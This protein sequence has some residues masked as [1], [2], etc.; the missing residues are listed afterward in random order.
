M[1]HPPSLALWKLFFDQGENGSKT[2]VNLNVHQ[3]AKEFPVV[4]LFSNAQ[5]KSN[6]LGWFEIYVYIVII[7]F[8]TN[9]FDKSINLLL[10]WSTTDKLPAGGARWHVLLVQKLQS[11]LFFA[12]ASPPAHSQ[13]QC[14]CSLSMAKRVWFWLFH[15]PTYL[16]LLPTSENRAF[17][18]AITLV[19]AP[20]H[21]PMEARGRY[22][23]VFGKCLKW[24][25][26]RRGLVRWLGK[27][28]FALNSGDKRGYDLFFGKL[29]LFFCDQ[30]ESII[31]VF[32]NGLQY[33]R[34]LSSMP[35]TARMKME[36][37][38]FSGAWWCTGKKICLL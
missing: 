36:F 33:C 10:M 19:K 12:A 25:G 17:W 29:N 26:G 27:Y 3:S 28:H 21:M 22:A 23:K 34:W 14:R 38:L 20:H 7:Y 2:Q 13:M 5:I 35:K 37:W 1:L 4:Q 15:I 31:L 9:N 16:H 30:T 24:W 32:S 18:T 6:C 8:I 11:N